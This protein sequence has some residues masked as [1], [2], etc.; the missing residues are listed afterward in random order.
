MAF[1]AEARKEGLRILADE[2]GLIFGQDLKIS[3]IADQTVKSP[4]YKEDVEKS[5]LCNIVDDKQTRKEEERNAKERE[6][7]K[8]RTTC[9]DSGASHC[10]VGELLHQIL[11]Q[12][13][14]EFQETQHTMTLVD[15]EKRQVEAFTTWVDI[16]LEGNVF[17]T[18]L[19]TLSHVK[20]N[21]TFLDTD[22][23]QNAGIILDLKSHKWF[24]NEI[25]SRKFN[26][27]K[28][29]NLCDIKHALHAEYITY[30]L[31]EGQQLSSERKNKHNTLLKQYERILEL[32]AEAT[33]QTK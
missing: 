13:V 30:K 9:V 29:I 14:A 15:G 28:E 5:L 17:K 33:L 7:D 18:N 2:M 8:E 20:E 6:L 4:Q 16:G 26:F 3:Q 11:K 25:P 24:F 19:I 23:L 1:L 21:R 12:K 10:I 22:F 32:G 27:V 31:R